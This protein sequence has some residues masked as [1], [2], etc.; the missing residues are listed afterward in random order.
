MQEA[1][2]CGT[3][4]TDCMAGVG[5][6]EAMQHYQDITCRMQPRC[7]SV[8]TKAYPVQAVPYLC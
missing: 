7:V 8:T 1:G 4:P 2:L 6:Q 3:Q 5:C